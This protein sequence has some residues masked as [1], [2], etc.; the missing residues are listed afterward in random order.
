M[1]NTNMNSPD[2]RL[3]RPIPVEVFRRFESQ[4]DW[5][6]YYGR[7]GTETHVFSAF[8]GGTPP[9][10]LASQATHVWLFVEK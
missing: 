10:D 1:C 8:Y 9:P 5:D 3:N 2:F 4:V 6:E 7:W